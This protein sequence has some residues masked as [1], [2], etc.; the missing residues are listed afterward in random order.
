MAARANMGKLGAGECARISD[1][2]VDHEP[3]CAA[4]LGNLSND[5]ADQRPACIATAVDHENVPWTKQLERLVD[6][7]IV[8]CRRP[9]REG[10]ARHRPAAVER[11]E[12]D[13]SREALKIVADD[14]CR[15]RPEARG[16]ARR[17]V[18][19]ACHTFLRFLAAWIY[20]KKTISQAS[21]ILGMRSAMNHTKK[22]TYTGLELVASS[23]CAAL[24]C[25]R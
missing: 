19:F 8:A 13:R 5:F 12:S 16:Q 23:C 9:D 7:A 15:C 2:A 4:V 24:N 18:A 22:D 14:G 25:S 1:R 17:L 20:I 21:G 3:G 6:R 10:R 11:T